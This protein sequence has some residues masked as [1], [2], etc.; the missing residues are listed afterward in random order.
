MEMEEVEDEGEKLN[1]E[2]QY[3]PSINVIKGHACCADKSCPEI[4]T[5]IKSRSMLLYP[6][7]FR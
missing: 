7:L 4:M 5:E 1:E 2:A 6:S 3:L